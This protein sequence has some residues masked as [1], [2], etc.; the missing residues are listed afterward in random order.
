MI[1]LKKDAV[2]INARTV[3]RR[4]REAVEVMHHFKKILTQ[5]SSS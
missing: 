4:L 5:G 2:N 3:R 1:S